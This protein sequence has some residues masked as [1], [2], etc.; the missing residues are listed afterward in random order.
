MSRSVGD[1]EGELADQGQPNPD[2][3]VLLQSVEGMLDFIQTQAA[4]YNKARTRL[5]EKQVQQSELSFA[6]QPPVDL[7]PTPTETDPRIWKQKMKNLSARLKQFGNE[8]SAVQRETQNALERLR[9]E[10]EHLKSELSKL[11]KETP[12]KSAKK[13]FHSYSATE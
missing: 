3:Y 9:S 7:P 1:S 8:R 4:Y 5:V 12:P 13:S 11:R 6:A 2:T 10:N